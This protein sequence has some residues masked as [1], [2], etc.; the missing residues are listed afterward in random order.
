M[1][2]PPPVASWE[3]LVESAW[4]KDRQ[5]SHGTLPPTPGHCDKT[6]RWL[7]SAMSDMQPELVVAHQGGID[8]EL[9]VAVYV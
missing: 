1:P 7:E 4:T 5:L 3:S 9:H 2:V 8:D 6:T